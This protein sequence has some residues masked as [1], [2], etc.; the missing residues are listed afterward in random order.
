MV[1]ELHD[2]RRGFCLREITM[3]L[4]RHLNPVWN[5]IR[6]GVKA[7]GDPIARLFAL[8]A[9]LDSVR[10]NTNE[11]SIQPP[12]QFSMSQRDSHLI[13]SL[14]RV[15]RMKRTR[16]INATDLDTL[17]LKICLRLCELRSREL[18]ATK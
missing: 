18:H 13:N 11:W 5:T 15:L 17:V 1:S 8:R 12:R 10:E 2:L 6:D 3:C 16:S 14:V 4:E 9:G 7:L